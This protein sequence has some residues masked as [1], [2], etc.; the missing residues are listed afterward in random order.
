MTTATTPELLTVRTARPEDIPAI[1]ALIQLYAAQGI[2]LPRAIDDLRDK[3]SD[4]VRICSAGT[5]TGGCS[6]AERL[7]ACGALD[8]Y[9]PEVAEIRSLAVDPA[10]RGAGLGRLVVEALLEQARAHRIELV[11]AFTYEV[12]FFTRL[13]FSRIDRTLLPW[14]VWKDCMLCPKRECC[15][16]TAVAIR[17]R[18]PMRRP[19]HIF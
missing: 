3:V 9:T 11:F 18:S 6:P 8:P 2:L 17:L 13:G 7:I 14:K 16:E 1:A 5:G 15:D 19:F 12:Q 10:H 4:F